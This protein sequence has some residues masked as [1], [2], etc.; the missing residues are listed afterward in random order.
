MNKH[1]I[2]RIGLPL[3]QARKRAA[4][5]CQLGSDTLTDNSDDTLSND[6]HGKAINTE[7]GMHSGGKELF[8]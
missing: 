1:Q 2:S 3:C 4:R 7:Q 8:S 6:K 5:H